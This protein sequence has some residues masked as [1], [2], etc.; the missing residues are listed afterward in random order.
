M[1]LAVH[2]VTKLFGGLAAL[3]EVSF[4]LAK[5]EIKAVIGPNGAGKTTLFNVITGILRPTSG[6]IEFA[7]RSVEGMSA[8]Q[9]ARLGIARTFQQ[10]QIFRSLTVL[11]NVMLG[12]DRYGRSGLLTCG[13]G[14]PRTRAEEARSVAAAYEQLAF[15]GLAGQAQRVASDLPLGEQRYVEITRA[16]ATGASLLLLDEPAAGL[17]ETETEQLSALILRIRARGVTVLL[18][19]HHMKFVMGIADSVLVLNFGAWLADGTPAAVRQSQEVIDAYLGNSE[20]A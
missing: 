4:D 2:G 5:G 17:D 1:M 14:L 10:P 20:D 7:H 18:I 16:L 11:E 12:A 13:L 19:E 3:R 6:R 9:I 8:L 15:T